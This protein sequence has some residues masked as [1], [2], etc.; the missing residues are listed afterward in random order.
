MC[1][2]GAVIL[3]TV[4]GASPGLLE[5]FGVHWQLLLIQSLNFL[6][7]VAILYYFAFKPI[8][9]TMEERKSKIENGLKYAED[10][11]AQL[12]DSEAVIRER[13]LQAKE[14]A[15]R[16]LEDAKH[17][18]KLYGD[19]QKSEIE[20]LTQEMIDSAKR[21]ITEEKARMLLN[22]KGEMKALV[23]AVAS[24]VLAKELS[25]V[26]RKRYLSEV[27]IHL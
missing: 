27:E 22:L 18:A 6:C 14:E 25:A 7:V 9:R 1:G 15:R 16:I 13:L 8:L 23:V 21:S 19:R 26:E 24:K 12:E 5:V 10:M 2:A 11:R 17:Q 3:A 4:H 20:Q